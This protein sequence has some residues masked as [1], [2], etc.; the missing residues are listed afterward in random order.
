MVPQPEEAKTQT[1]KRR[2]RKPNRFV[3]H[4]QTVTEIRR[5]P[6]S[7]PGRLRGLLLEM[8]ISRGGG[9]YG[10]GYVVAFA[11]FEVQMITGELSGSNSVGEFV[12]GQTLEYVLR[13]GFMSFVSALQALL[14]PAFVAGWWNG[15]GLLLLIGGYLAFEYLL[16]PRVEAVFPELREHRLARERRKAE[17][18]EQRAAKKEKRAERRRRRSGGSDGKAN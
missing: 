3:R 17:K 15:G 16:K 7:I 4:W 8:W 11:Y 1:R 9:F 12:L 10:I 13:L 18:V 6:R 5:D 14:W 2:P